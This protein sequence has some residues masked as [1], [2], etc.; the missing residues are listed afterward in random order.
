MRG[1]F[2]HKSIRRSLIQFLDLFRSIYIARYDSNGYAKKIIRVPIS[3]GPKEKAFYWLQSGGK[4]TNETL[5]LMSANI[6]AIDFDATRMT[7]R[8]QA[9]VIERDLTNKTLKMFKNAIPYNIGI[10]LNLWALHMVDIDQILEQILPF[11][12]PHNFIRINF[13]ELSARMDIKVILNNATPDITE[14]MAEE[15]WRV[16]KWILSFTLQTYVLRPI[17]ISTSD[18]S[19]EESYDDYEETPPSGSGSLPG[20]GFDMGSGGVVFISSGMIDKLL[21]R[22]FTNDKAWEDRGT[23]TVIVSG[24]EMLASEAMLFEGLGYDEDAKILFDYEVFE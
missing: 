9:I 4:K 23:E 22:L 13:P 11:F 3:F 8:E 19:S 21:V 24:A 7:N 12:A 17:I 2:F 18:S 14:E 6:T 1:Y 16:I 5:P 10:N 15:D 20:L